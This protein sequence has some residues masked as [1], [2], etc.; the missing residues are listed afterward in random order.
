[1]IK[2]WSIDWYDLQ[3][4][5]A[6]GDTVIDTYTK[7]QET[8]PQPCEREQFHEL[9]PLHI[10]IHTQ[11]G[12]EEGWVSLQSEWSNYSFGSWCKEGHMWDAKH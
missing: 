9:N 4:A 10:G 12:A 8:E 2:V 11:L 3:P 6:G 1:M 7:I 5:A